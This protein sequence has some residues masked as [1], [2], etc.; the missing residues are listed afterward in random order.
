MIRL[1]GAKAEAVAQTAVVRDG[2]RV[3]STPNRKTSPRSRGEFSQ[4][5]NLAE[6][7]KKEWRG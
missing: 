6:E 3:K 4:P 1:Q 5:T 2:M 7:R